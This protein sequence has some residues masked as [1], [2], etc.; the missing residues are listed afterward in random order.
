[1]IWVLFIVG[2]VFLIVG[3]DI[4]VKGSASIAKFYKIPDMVV[5]LTIVSIGTSMP[6]LIVNLIAS[7]SGESDIAVGNVF[8]SNIA[9][10][11]LILGASAIIYPLPIVRNTLLTELPIVLVATLLVGFLANAAVFDP[12]LDLTLSRWDGIILMIFFVFFM[13]YIF[14]LAK[15]GKQEEMSDGEE[16]ELLPMWKSISFIVAGIIGLFIG[17]K[18][19]V[20][21]AVEIA[22]MFGLSESFIGLTIVAV[23]TSLPEMVT[24]MIAAHKRNTDIAVGNIVGSNIFNLLWILG[25]SAIINPLPFNTV[26]NLDIMVMIFSSVMLLL[27]LAFSKNNTVTRGLGV[28]FILSYV[29]YIV[30]LINRS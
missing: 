1:M 12:A 3:A 4:L 17:G 30:F 18:W 29:G 8:G 15:S 22:R 20:D 23:G 27:P 6:E 10:V 25:I 2:F 24:S 11:L 28:F 13:I 14:H 16:I 26:S 7:F 19:V 5:G 9:N 21:G